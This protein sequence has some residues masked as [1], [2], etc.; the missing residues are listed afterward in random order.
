MS[1]WVWTLGGLG[2]VRGLEGETFRA[3]SPQ[4]LLC[5]ARPASRV[6]HP[7]SRTGTLC[8]ER[9]PLGLALCSHRLNTGNRFEQG[10]F[11][12]ILHGALHMGH[13]F[14]LQGTR[15]RDSVPLPRAQLVSGTHL[16]APHGQA[17]ANAP[18]SSS[19]PGGDGVSCCCWALG[20]ASS[21]G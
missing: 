1:T 14:C 8:S 16:P 5:W 15:G 6:C 9:P 10:V 4:L 2:R 21:I 19:H 13:S 20:P 11:V 17:P 3:L 18:T 12:F 7:C